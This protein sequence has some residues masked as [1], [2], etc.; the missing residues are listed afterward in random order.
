[1]ANEYAHLTLTDLLLHQEDRGWKESFYPLSFWRVYL[2]KK[3]RHSKTEDFLPRSLPVTFHNFGNEFT[4]WIKISPT[5]HSLLAHSWELFERNGGDFVGELSESGLE[6]DNKFIKAIHTSKISEEAC[7]YDTDSRIWDQSNPN[8]NSFQ[9][10]THPLS[11]AFKSTKEGADPLEDRINDLDF[12]WATLLLLFISYFIYTS[13]TGRI[14][15]NFNA[16]KK[17]QNCE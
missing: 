2:F 14:C 5:V 3:D 1:M 10:V 8:M 11:T 7:P 9:P 15:P 16:S 17:H 4:R 13:I 12:S 6:A